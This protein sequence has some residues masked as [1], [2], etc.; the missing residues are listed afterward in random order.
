MRVIC[1][2]SCGAA[3]AVLAEMVSYHPKSEIVY[4]DTSASEHPDQARFAADIEQW[5]HRPVIRIR[6]PL[7]QTIWE[8]FERV[9]Y[10]H[11]PNGSPC[12]KYLKREV[13]KSYQQPDDVH[14]FGYTIEEEDRIARFEDNNPSLKCIWPLR[15]AGITKKDCYNRLFEV[16]ISLPTMYTLGYH[17]NNCIGCVKGGMGYW[18]KIRRD[19]PA[20][21][22]RMATL[23]RRFNFALFKRQG[24]PCFLDELPPDV[25]R[26]SE[27]PPLSCGPECVG[28]D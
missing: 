8:V 20:V 23:E 12:T 10:L 7:Y 27:E 16:G 26:Y 24:Q 11:G 22:D 2:F 6:S 21:F 28:R 19:F 25:G 9:C 15:D 17:N 4:C 3:S 14:A 5:L 13:R 18:N 1:W